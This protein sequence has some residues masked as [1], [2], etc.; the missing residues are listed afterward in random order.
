MIVPNNLV[1][2][3]LF[4]LCN[5]KIDSETNIILLCKRSKYDNYKANLSNFYDI[6]QLDV[7]ISYSWGNKAHVTTIRNF[8]EEKGIGCWIDDQ[9]LLCGMELLPEIATA[10]RNSKVYITKNIYIP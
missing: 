9:N 4:Q 8:L 2:N 5:I 10:I 3:I 1:S 7:F 6:G